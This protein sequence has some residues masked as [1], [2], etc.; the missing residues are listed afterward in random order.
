FGLTS[1]AI[2]VDH[3][4][5][6]REDAAARVL[7]T[8]ETFWN[9]PQGAGS[10][11]TIGYQGLFYHFLDMTTATRTWSCELSTIDTAL[12]MA[13]VLDAKHYFD[14]VDATE[15]QIRA[16]ADSLYERVDWEWARNSGVGVRMGW[17]PETGFGGFGTWVGYNEAM[18][19][20]IL[21]LGS[22][23]HPIPASTWF[24][25]TSGYVWNF[26]YG[27]EYV[28]FPPLFG[29]QY[30]H[31]WID[32]RFIQDVY[33]ANRGSTYYEN[34]RR[35]TYAAREYCIANPGGWV[36]Y[37]PDLWGL[38][39]SD[40]PSGYVAHG[41]PPPQNDN[42]TIT[43]TAAISSIPFAPE[44]VI[45][46]MHHMYDV[47]GPGLWATYG[48]KDAFNPTVGWYATDYLGIDQGPIAIMIQN[49]YDASVWERFMQEPA[50]QTGLT[51]ATFTAATDVHVAEGPE[52]AWLMLAQN[53]PN[54]FSEATSI[55]YE[56]ARDADVSIELFD[57]AGR[58][59]R[60]LDASRRAA[61]RHVV[62]LGA[63]DLA[64]G[65]YYYRLRSGDTWE[66]KKCI[67]LR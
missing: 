54:P 61:G 44:I 3:G 1:I 66:G 25:W 11:G 2:G 37:G 64:N 46:A 59:V 43:P 39:A 34:S 24:T 18:I 52:P 51:R 60:V 29:H 57:V 50:V 14:G 48:F 23:T 8:L 45:P 47:Y 42:G 53:A 49:Y 26:H 20:Y 4:W 62:R 30:S 55:S 67:L 41:A 27:Y 22:P 12:L 15:I 21:A 17:T 9:G 7:T 63:T 10:S 28:Q 32:Y 6:T 58:R 56:I 19:L 31:C 36:G 33:M 5:V 13:G 35:A 38:T 40:D 65:V 16:V